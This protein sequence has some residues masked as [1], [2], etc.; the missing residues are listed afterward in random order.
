MR[1]PCPPRPRNSRVPQEVWAPA[2]ELLDRQPAAGA[3]GGMAA[4]EQE[5]GGVCLDEQEAVGGTAA[6]EQVQ[7]GG[8]LGEIE[9]D[10]GDD[11]FPSQGRYLPF[12]GRGSLFPKALHTVRLPL[13]MP[14]HLTT[15][16]TVN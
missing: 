4:Q 3:G 1:H 16:G 11:I 10:L 9:A 6:Q 14:R 12:T 5:Q 8:C 7:G 2:A 13:H 15:S